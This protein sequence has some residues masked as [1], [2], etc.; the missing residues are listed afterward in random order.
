MTNRFMGAQWPRHGFLRTRDT[1]EARKWLS[2]LLNGELGPVSAERSLGA[3]QG[4]TINDFVERVTSSDA[5]VS[6]QRDEGLS[7]RELETLI[8]GCVLAIKES[9]RFECRSIPLE[10]DDRL[11]PGI[12][13]NT[14]LRIESQLRDT[15]E[16][17]RS[18]VFEGVNLGLDMTDE[19]GAG[20]LIYVAEKVAA[21]IRYREG[22]E[23]IRGARVGGGSGAP[24]RPE[25]ILAVAVDQALVARKPAKR[26]AA[27]SVLI[28]DVLKVSITSEQIRARLNDFYRRNPRK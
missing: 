14:L 20:R 7:L 24:L 9:V 16:S 26:Y 3:E 23:A 28:R 21:R 1:N 11:T 18:G 13:T 19:I 15:A 12:S 22:R 8:V 10:Q 5:F 2:A 17:L 6:A 27:T 25:T 4:S